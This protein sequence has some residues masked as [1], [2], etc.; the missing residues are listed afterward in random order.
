MRK[1]TYL[2]AAVLGALSVSA[3]AAEN[4]KI[5]APGAKSDNGM[6]MQDQSSNNG[7]VVGYVDTGNDVNKVYI[8]AHGSDAKGGPYSQNMVLILTSDNGWA[9]L[10]ENSTSQQY[11][12]YVNG[13][14]DP[15]CFF[16]L[17]KY[18]QQAN[19]DWMIKLTDAKPYHPGGDYSCTL[20]QGAHS[21][22]VSK[23]SSPQ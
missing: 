10:P 19:G 23:N 15:V 3:I 22:T 4:M 1:L 9:N 21:L 6:M 14:T 8:A 16:T 7:Y 5:A 2:A 18:Q 12:V 13:Q 11:D 20:N 17:A